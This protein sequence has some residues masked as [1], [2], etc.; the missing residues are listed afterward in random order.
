[1]CNNVF[2]IGFKFAINSYFLVMTTFINFFSDKFQLQCNR[3]ISSNINEKK[4]EERKLKNHD[5]IAIIYIIFTVHESI[6]IGLISLKQK[7]KRELV[8]VAVATPLP[9]IAYIT[10]GLIATQIF[11]RYTFFLF[12]SITCSELF[13][14]LTV[15]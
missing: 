6:E 9:R 12:I 8:I 14:I 7:R 4:R 10:Y 1:M 5:E 3:K 11:G 2:D 15:V 13:E